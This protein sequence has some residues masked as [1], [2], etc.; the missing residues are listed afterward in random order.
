MVLVN[1]Y[2]G[3]ITSSLTTPKMKPQINTLEE[4]AASKEVKIVLR[5]DT[6][7]GVQIL[8]MPHFC[9]LLWDFRYA[10]ESFLFIYLNK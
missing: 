9:V 3:I 4:S 5:S 8:V 7:T 6:S 10:P 2:T 1:S